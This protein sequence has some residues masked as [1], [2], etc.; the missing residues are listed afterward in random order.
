MPSIRLAALSN[1][2]PRWRLNDTPFSAGQRRKADDGVADFSRRLS[3]AS[4]VVE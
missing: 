4:D 2:V 3:S 1:S